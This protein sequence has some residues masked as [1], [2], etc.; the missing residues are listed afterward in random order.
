MLLPTRLTALFSITAAIF[1]LSCTPSKTEEKQE[2]D[3]ATPSPVTYP[4]LGN[5]ELAKLYAD[6]EKADIIFYNLPISV[7]QDDATSAKNSA[8]YVSPAP[9]I[10]GTS[11]KPMGRLSWIADGA[12]IKEADFYA[13]SLCRYFVFMTNNQPAAANA[14]S[15][16]GY[17]FFKSVITQVQQRTQ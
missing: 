4:S 5:E 17:Q 10:M 11:C 13:D 1:I 16:S 2:V 15:E 14:M 8:L 7:N 12:I 6:A 3:E 9:A